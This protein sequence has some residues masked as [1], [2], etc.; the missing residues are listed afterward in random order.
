M[1]LDRARSCE[2]GET[3]LRGEGIPGGK[4]SQNKDTE[5][6]VSSWS[7][8]RERWETQPTTVVSLG[9]RSHWRVM[10]RANLQV[11]GQR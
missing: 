9:E 10:G 5:R 8:A 3:G 6:P 4:N 7:L 2:C 1:A 11:W